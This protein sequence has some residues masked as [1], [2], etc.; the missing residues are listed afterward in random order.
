M[1]PYRLVT[2]KLNFFERLTRWN[3]S[4]LFLVWI[5]LNTIFTFLYFVLSLTHPQH[6]PTFMGGIS[7]WARLF[8]SLYFS[9]ITAT[10]VGYGDILPLGFSKILVMIQS[11]SALLI[12]TVLVGKLVGQR[13]DATL[14]EVHRM[15][16][17]GVFYHIRHILFIVR[18]DFDTLIRRVESKAP[19]TPHDWDTLSTAYL[20]AHS[21]VEEIP[22]LYGGHSF[23]LHSIDLNR[24][25]LLF[26]ALHRTLSRIHTLLESM[27]KTEIDWRAHEPSAKEFRR[28]IDMIDGIMPLW[29]ER[30]PFH[31]EQEFEDIRQISAQLHTEMKAKVTK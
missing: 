3:Y 12:F 21:L 5:L 23:N 17:E 1:N 26:E 27:N 20:Q 30:S 2:G 29:R 25:K 8:D 11:S 18:K 14:H 31:E 10:T 4:E 7:I 22:E 24:E 28:L 16:F 9:V 6:G 13:Q 19:L 15:T